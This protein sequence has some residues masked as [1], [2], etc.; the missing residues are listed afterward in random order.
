MNKA[1][2]LDRDGTINFD[3]DHVFDPDKVILLPGASESLKILRENGF[4][5]IIV[6]NQSCIAR[7]YAS[8]DDVNK[9]HQKLR[10]LLLEQSKD[11]IIDLIQVAPDHPNTPTERRKPSAGM[12]LEAA[13]NLNLDLNK[14]WIIGD[15][16]SDPEA[17]IAAG[18]PKENCLL[19]KPNQNKNISYE[20]N[21][22]KTFDT[23]L[24]ASRFILGGL[25][26]HFD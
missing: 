18:L 13:E 14:C 5:I 19:L 2:F 9:T 15:K 10:Q 4:K 7:G 1:V 3:S 24:E 26:T 23:I 20:N 16:L 8:Y 21:P 6:T 25:S 17:G 11:A 22:F 12:L